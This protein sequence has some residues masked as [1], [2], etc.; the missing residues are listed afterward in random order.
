MGGIITG[1]A[2]LSGAC[3]SPSHHLQRYVAG[4]PSGAFLKGQHPRGGLSV[5]FTGWLFHP[6]SILCTGSAASAKPGSSSTA[7]CTSIGNRTQPHMEQ[8]GGQTGR[9]CWHLRARV[10]GRMEGAGQRKRRRGRWLSVTMATLPRL[11]RPLLRHPATHSPARKAGPRQV[12][13]EQERRCL[14][15]GQLEAGAWNVFTLLND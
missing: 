10:E 11:I 3:R 14:V 2:I 9:C 13:L 1:D 7:S 12:W 15:I 6:I 5:P 8:L 4:V